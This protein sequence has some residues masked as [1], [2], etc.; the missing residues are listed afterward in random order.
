MKRNFGNCKGIQKAEYT[1]PE[2][3][4]V[5]SYTEIKQV[6]EEVTKPIERRVTVRARLNNPRKSEQAVL[7]ELC[8]RVKARQPTAKLV[9]YER[10][11][12][13]ESPKKPVRKRRH[14]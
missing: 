4:A 8:A 2:L 5:L 10:K 14:A 7:K 11:E 3:V 13:A 9:S 12:K 6:T 1:G